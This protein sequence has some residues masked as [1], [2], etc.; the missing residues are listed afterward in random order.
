MNEIEKL[1]KAILDLH[2]CKSMHMQTVAVQET[3]QGK[4]VWDGTV[5]T[6]LLKNHPK[7]KLA[8]AWSYKTDDGS[9]QHVAVLALPPVATPLDAVRAYIASQAKKQ[10]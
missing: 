3:Y 1:E 6:F 8:F 10:T 4:I 5:E 7:A 9:I 2:G